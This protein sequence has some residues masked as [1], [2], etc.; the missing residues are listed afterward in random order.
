M[1]V[2]T[3]TQLYQSASYFAQ[4]FVR[5]GDILHLRLD[6]S[7]FSL[8]LV[9]VRFQLD[10]L[11]AVLRLECLLLLRCRNPLVRAKDERNHREHH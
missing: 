11:F 4:L 1:R 10:V 9:S 2:I 7:Q 5:G 8:D 6:F 3:K